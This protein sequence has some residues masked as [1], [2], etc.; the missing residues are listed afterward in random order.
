MDPMEFIYIYIYLHE[1]RQK[2]TKF[3]SKYT[4]NLD[5]MGYDIQYIRYIE[6]DVTIW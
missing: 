2:S 6:N 5:G 1:T 4:V 3:V